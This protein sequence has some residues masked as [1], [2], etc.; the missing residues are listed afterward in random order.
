MSRMNRFKE[1]GKTIVFVSH[2]LETVRS[3]CGEAVWLDHG[4]L[5]E[6][7]KPGD[8]V[9]AYVTSLNQRVDLA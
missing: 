1:M 8:V 2:D 9:D 7:G 3:W 6:R 4:V 5:C